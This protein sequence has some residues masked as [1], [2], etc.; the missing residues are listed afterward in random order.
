M[1][2]DDVRMNEDLQFMKKRVAEAEKLFQDG[3][4]KLAHLVLITVQLRIV[5]AVQDFI[6]ER[7]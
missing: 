1:T 5:N 4:W 3:N 7:R 6:D 2:E